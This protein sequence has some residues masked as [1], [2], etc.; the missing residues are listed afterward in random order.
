MTL[1]YNFM[2]SECCKRSCK[3]ILIT[4]ESSWPL[5]DFTLPGRPECEE[6]GTES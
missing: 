2:G 4:C 6:E 5:R 1:K 3:V